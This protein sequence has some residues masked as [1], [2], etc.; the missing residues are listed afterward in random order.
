MKNNITIKLLVLFIAV[1]LWFHQI[2]IKTHSLEINIPIKLIKTPQSLIPDSSRLPEVTVEISA[3]GKDILLLHLSKKSFQIDTSY[4]RYGKNK[5]VPKADQLI[6][7]DKIII[8]INSIDKTENFFI[9]MDKLVERSKP[10]KI[11]YAS[12][13]DEEFFIKNKVKNAN[14]KITIRGP[15][16]LIN[17]VEYILTKKISNKIIKNGR[18]IIQLIS[19]N[20][21]IEILQDEIE[22]EITNTKII[23]KT[24]SL[25]PIKYPETEN[26]TIIPQKVSVMVSGPKEIV[27]QLNK[28]T[29][30]A[31]LNTSILN[32]D[33]ATVSFKVPSGVK[34]IEY[35]PQK[36]QVIQND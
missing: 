1:I 24:I 29:I 5:I 3:T 31:N 21:K 19:P 13:K 25:I 23:R 34:I 7:S 8:K 2:L 12:A 33:F 10:I 9:N 35:T 30:T 32:K 17:D 16:A 28:N 6:Y 4:F 27:E 36:I 15:L 11:Q 18:L 14:K 26:I 22:F 20:P